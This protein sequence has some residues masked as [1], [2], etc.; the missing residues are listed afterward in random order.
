MANGTREMERW[1]DGDGEAATTG[2]KRQKRIF[3]TFTFFLSLN[4][5]ARELAQHLKFERNCIFFF[6]PLNFGEEVGVKN[7]VIYNTPI[8]S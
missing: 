6:L 8:P 5:I 2:N 7:L 4:L 1:R 3:F